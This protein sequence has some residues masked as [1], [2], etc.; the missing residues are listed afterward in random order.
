MDPNDLTRHAAGFLN[1]TEFKRTRDV[2]EI[3]N[4]ISSHYDFFN[5]GVL[6]YLVSLLPSS[7]KSL[8]TEL[9]QYNAMVNEFSD[10]SMLKHIRSVINERLS[11]LMTMDP[12]SAESVKVEITL[13]E[14]WELTTLGNLKVVLN[15]YFGP[16]MSNFMHHIRFSQGSLHIQFLVLKNMYSTTLVDKI[17]L[18][19]EALYRIGMFKLDVGERNIFVKE[20]KIDFDLHSLVISGDYFE[21]SMLL[22]LGAY[23]NSKNKEGKTALILA[24]ETN[25]ET[26]LIETILAA[27]AD[28]KATDNEGNT[29]FDIVLKKDIT[30][31]MMF[32]ACEKGHY[33]VVRFLLKGPININLPN[34]SSLLILASQNGHHQI[35]QLLIDEAKLD[36]NFQNKDGKTALICATE[37]GHYSVVSILVHQKL[38]NIDVKDKDG[39]TAFHYASQNGFTK[40]ASLLVKMSAVTY[41]VT[42]CGCTPLMLAGQSGHMATVEFLITHTFI[43]AYELMKTILMTDSVHVHL[44]QIL[45]KAFFGS[46]EPTVT[47]QQVKYSVEKFIDKCD[48]KYCYLYYRCN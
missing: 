23:V 11:S 7:K 41:F 14:R 40:I 1:L 19:T 16:E 38:I 28:M 22:Q 3:F 32:S 30:K 21:L 26:K 20:D 12:S 42:N 18:Q 24:I 6:K 44:L 37:G 27:G 43:S 10:S 33:Q 46:I 25:Q 15:H 13:N 47:V 4:A 48:S 39:F 45:A 9:E 36:Y 34:D 31:M 17:S 35:V 29:A 5:Y 2:D 8:V